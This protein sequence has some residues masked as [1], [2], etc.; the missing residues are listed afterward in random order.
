MPNDYR[1]TIVSKYIKKC[2]YPDYN[3]IVVKAYNKHL[4]TRNKNLSE[5][6]L[7]TNLIDVNGNNIT[8]D[9]LLK[10]QH[11]KK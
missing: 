7:S 4:L 5:E 8:L 9:K 10:K 2:P 11:K 6:V 3:I 1:D